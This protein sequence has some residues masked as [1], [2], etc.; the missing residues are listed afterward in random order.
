M[1]AKI[2]ANPDLPQIDDYYEPFDFDYQNL[3]TAKDSQHQPTARP[4]SLISGERMQK[5]EW[6]PNWEEILG[7][8]GN[9]RRLREDL[10]DVPAAPVR[11][12]PEP[13]VRIGVPVWRDLQA[14]GRRHR[15]DRPGQVPWLA[16]VRVG[17]PVQ[18]D[19][20]QLEERQVGEVHLLLPAQRDGRADRVLGD[21]RGSHPLPGRD[22][23]RRR[24][25]CRGCLGGRREGP[26]PGAPGHLPGPERPG[27]DRCRA[28]GRHSGQL[29]GRGQAVAGLQAGHRLEAGAAAAPGVPHAAD[30]LV[31]AAAF[32]D[33]VGGRA[34]PGR[35]ERRTAGRGL[36]AYP[37]AL[38]G[39]PADRR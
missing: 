19:L 17:L 22:A 26:V 28:Q 33:P 6:G 13:G 38:P 1:L 5:I 11:A 27:G 31:R 34:W 4:R 16:H 3:H 25:H 2:F 32:A 39:E 18:E 20:L 15:A 14:R 36:A 9:L 29:A 21:L 30:G 24:P 35:N 8:E 37:D 12:L 10:H 7:A 23:V